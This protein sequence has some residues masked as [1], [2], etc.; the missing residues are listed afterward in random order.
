MGTIGE[1]EGTPGLLATIGIDWSCWQI[2][3]VSRCDDDNGL[4]HITDGAVFLMNPD[5]GPSSSVPAARAHPRRAPSRLRRSRRRVGAPG[6]PWRQW[7]RRGGTVP[8]KIGRRTR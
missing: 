4:L 5:T 3:D 8:W 6:S 2:T 1:T 7:A